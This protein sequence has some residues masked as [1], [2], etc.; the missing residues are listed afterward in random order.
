MATSADA[1]PPQSWSR[2]NPRDATQTLYHR[3]QVRDGVRDWAK[4]FPSP[5]ERD[6]SSPVLQ[7]PST[8]VSKVPIPAPAFMRARI[9]TR[10]D[11]DKRTWFCNRNK[12]QDPA[13]CV[14]NAGNNGSEYLFFAS[15]V[16]YVLVLWYLKR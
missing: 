1:F 6:A 12:H 9:S 7:N 3:M 11:E 16:P 15:Q 14:L 10:L 5:G 2:R 8:R 4:G 13:S